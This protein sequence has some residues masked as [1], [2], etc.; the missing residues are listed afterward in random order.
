MICLQE[1]RY[2]ILWVWPIKSRH[3]AVARGPT[4]F[5]KVLPP[6]Q[7]RPFLIRDIDEIILVFYEMNCKKSVFPS[8]NRSKKGYTGRLP[9]ACV[10]CRLYVSFGVFVVRPAIGL[11]YILY[12]PTTYI[13]PIVLAC[14]GCETWCGELLVYI[15]T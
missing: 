10:L 4:R 11:P 13:N 5:S 14:H 6:L 12:I 9:I 8:P 3:T 1:T 2:R 15:H 7:Y